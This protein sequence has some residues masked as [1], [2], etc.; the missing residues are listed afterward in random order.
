MKNFTFKKALACLI[1]GIILVV[2][3]LILTKLIYFPYPELFIYPYLTNHGLKPYSQIFDQHFP[4]LMFLPVNLDNLGMNTPEA[5]RIWSISIILI[6]HL[7]IF[8][9]GSEIF[10]S[11]T[12]ALLANGLFLIWNPFFE[13]WV[14]WIDSFLPLLLLPAFYAL[15][16]KKLFIAGILLGMGIVFKQT[17]IP[18]SVLVLIYIFWKTRNLKVCLR[19][20]LGLSVPVSVMI[21]YIISIGVFWDFWYW[22]VFYNLTTYAQSGTKAPPSVGYVTRIVFVY[23]VSLFAFINW[24]KEIIPLIFVF[25]IGSLIGAFERADFVHLQPSLPFVVL[26]TVY[27]FGALGRLGRWGKLGIWVGYFVVLVWW[28]NIFYKGHFGDR[29]ISFDANT[30]MLAVKI[31]EYTK[32]GEK[33]F[34]F[35][36]EP[37]LYQ[38]SD[39]LPAGDVFVFQF[40][41]F[42]KVAE[43]RILQGIMLDKPGIIISD[44]NVIIEG[45]KITEFAK[46]IDQYIN[47]NYQKIDKVGTAD[48][49]QR[50]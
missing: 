38:M 39:T 22:T 9:I 29:V 1:L 16:K 33:I 17:I 7:M 37:Q 8:L 13:G 28:L 48:I 47:Q 24:K 36:G 5:A 46:K 25:I 19:F 3:V 27:G 41:W 49:L 31:R 42:L 2:H 30:K 18:L 21:L 35:G 4:G 15:Y 14:L 12:K 34:V 10:R 11:R 40:P 32:P 26:A 45:Q 43:G 23:G 50:R 20:L 44:R 6:I